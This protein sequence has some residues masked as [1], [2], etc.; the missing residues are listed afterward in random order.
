MNSCWVELELEGVQSNPCACVGFTRSIKLCS[1]MALMYGREAKELMRGEDWIKRCGGSAGLLVLR[2]KIPG[3]E[4]VMLEVRLGS[5]VPF[6]AW[7]WGAV[8]LSHSSASFLPES[9][10]L[11]GFPHIA[12]PNIPIYCSCLLVHSELGVKATWKQRKS[13]LSINPLLGM[14][15]K[16]SSI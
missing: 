14:K 11:L 7:W 12:P 16:K 5:I 3:V 6:Q 8:W 2:C 10:W 15:N 1:F 9:G 4:R 13:I